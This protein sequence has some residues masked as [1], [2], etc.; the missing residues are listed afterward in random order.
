MSLKS[1]IGEREYERLKKFA[2]ERFGISSQFKLVNYQSGTLGTYVR[3][4]DTIRIDCRLRRKEFIL[5]LLHEAGHA[6]CTKYGI[7]RDFHMVSGR[8][9]SDISRK[10]A[11]S[12]MR[13]GIKAERYVDRIAA[14]LANEF[15]PRNHYVSNLAEPEQRQYLEVN[16]KGFVSAGLLKPRKR[17][18]LDGKI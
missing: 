4:K 16:R 3:Q 18:E 2:R 9:Y 8:I 11:L 13:T 10:E 7:F 12:Y 14:R 1:P 15:D 6:Y 5:T 17:G